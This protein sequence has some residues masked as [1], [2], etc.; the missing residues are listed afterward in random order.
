M[1]TYSYTCTACSH[2]TELVASMMD[3][4]NTVE[5]P[6]CGEVATRSIRIPVG[7]ILKGAGWARDGYDKQKKPTKPTKKEPT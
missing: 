5:C 6:K 4:P 1:P 2:D 3:H 7:F